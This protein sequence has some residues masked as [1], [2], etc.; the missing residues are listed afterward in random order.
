MYCYFHRRSM[1]I[2][3]FQG[4]KK[5]AESKHSSV[6]VIDSL[7]QFAKQLGTLGPV[8]VIKRCL[9]SVFVDGQSQRQKNHKTCWKATRT[10]SCY[11]KPGGTEILRASNQS[12]EESSVSHEARDSILNLNLPRTPRKLF[13]PSLPL[14]LSCP[15]NQNTILRAGKTGRS[16]PPSLSRCTDGDTEARRERQGLGQQHAEDP[17]SRIPWRRKLKI[18]THAVQQ[19]LAQHCNSSILLIKN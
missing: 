15:R 13:M 11:L 19:K 1:R 7:T 12:E 4:I 2:S 16:L 9:L 10:I 3:N 5:K 8:N 6:T 14:L 18:K 17:E